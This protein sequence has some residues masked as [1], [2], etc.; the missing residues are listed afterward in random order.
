MNYLKIEIPYF[1]YSRYLV[2]ISNTINLHFNLINGLSKERQSEYAI[3]YN[4]VKYHYGK[5]LL[6]VR[7]HLY[8][9]PDGLSDTTS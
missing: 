6:T 8:L 5:L 2:G 3:E 4:C 1:D 9:D 7:I